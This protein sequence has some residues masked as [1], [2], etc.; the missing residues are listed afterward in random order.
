MNFGVKSA[1]HAK[2]LII[3]LKRLKKNI[4]K[5]QSLA[6]ELLQEVLLY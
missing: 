3:T 5:F 6:M 2:K 4:Q 1:L